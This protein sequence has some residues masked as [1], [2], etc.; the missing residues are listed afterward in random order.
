MISYRTSYPSSNPLLFVYSPSISKAK[1]TQMFH[2]AAECKGNFGPRQCVW[3]RSTNLQRS[4][5]SL[6]T[7]WSS[8]DPVAKSAPMDF[9]V[10]RLNRLKWK[11]TMKPL[12]PT[13]THLEF[14][15]FN[16]SWRISARMLKGYERSTLRPSKTQLNATQ[17]S[18]HKSMADA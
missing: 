16:C 3:R 6:C 15:S 11:F 18:V 5:T 17:L 7:A 4:P 8:L 10:N 2:P 9:R 13:W 14:G 12:H 1:A